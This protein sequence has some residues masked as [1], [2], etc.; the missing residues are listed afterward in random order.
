MDG[1]ELLNEV[2]K[3]QRDSFAECYYAPFMINSRNYRHISEETEAWFEKLGD[4][5]AASCQLTQREDHTQAVACFRILFDLID[6]MEKGEEIVFGDEIGSW[7]ISGDEKECIPA[8]M[9]S[10][11]AT[12]APEEFTQAAI[13]LVRSD[14]YTAFAGRAYNIALEAAQAEQRAQL[15]AEVK[16][17][18]IRVEPQR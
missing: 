3:F 7:M 8:Y 16:R 15:E 12:A 6:A 18:G 2:E 14:S 1:K 9:T 10:L 4:Y 11:A 13:P 17:Q 5:L